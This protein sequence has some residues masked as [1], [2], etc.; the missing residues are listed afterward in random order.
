MTDAFYIT[1]LICFLSNSFCTKA[2]QKT[3]I[4]MMIAELKLSTFYHWSGPGS[5]EQQPK[6]GCPDP[7]I[8]GHSLQL[9]QGNT[10]TLL[11]Q[12]RGIISPAC[13]MSD[14]VCLFRKYFTD[15]LYD[16]QIKMILLIPAVTCGSVTSVSIPKSMTLYRLPRHLPVMM[17]Q[18]Y[19]ILSFPPIPMRVTFIV[20][21][22]TKSSSTWQCK[23]FRV[24]HKGVSIL[25]WATSS[26]TALQSC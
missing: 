5:Q 15:T 19:L 26:S 9:F 17:I 1:L 24:I 10:D 23:I 18:N 2:E 7:F 4:P 21:S 25:I 6:Q 8:A 3:E 13:H 20:E 11:S 12:L 16:N 14:P 22:K